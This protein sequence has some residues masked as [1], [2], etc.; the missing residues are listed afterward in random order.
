[1]TL[2]RTDRLCQVLEANLAFVVPHIERRDG[3]TG[4]E[5]S[6]ARGRL[7]DGLL[8]GAA[9]FCEKNDAALADTLEHHRTATCLN[10]DRFIGELPST[11]NGLGN[12]KGSA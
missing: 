11:A 3:H 5:L 2:D 9:T 4:N 12:S 7:V 1:M 6:E 10:G 8:G